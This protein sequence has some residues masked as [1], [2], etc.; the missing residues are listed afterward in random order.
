MRKLLFLLVISPLA[1]VAQT[2]FG[3]FSY[4]AVLDSLPQYK[5]AMQDYDK[6]KERCMKEIDHNELQLTRFYVAFLDGQREFPEPILRK[7]QKELQQMIDNSVVFRDQLK[8]WLRH[9]KDSL[10]VP[11]RQAIDS[12][13]CR[14]CSELSL[15]HAVDTDRSGYRYINPEFGEDITEEILSVIFHPELPL[16]NAVECAEPVDS[17]SSVNAV[18]MTKLIP[19]TEITVKEEVKKDSAETADAAPLFPEMKR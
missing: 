8:V 17:L 10:T 11:S 2:K 14:V 6:L 13:L 16:R 18:P 1:I 19:A 4:S 15:S 12:A 5:E 7:R 3:Y 9:A